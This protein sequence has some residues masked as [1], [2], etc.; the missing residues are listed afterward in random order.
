MGNIKH[1]TFKAFPNSSRMLSRRENTLRKRK[2]LKGKQSNM[3]ERTH[4]EHKSRSIHIIKPSS[5]PCQTLVP[6]GRGAIAGIGKVQIAKACHRPGRSSGRSG[7]RTVNGRPT[8]AESEVD[9]RRVHPRLLERF[10][11]LLSLLERFG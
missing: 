3:H 10:G 11:A 8:S 5:L 1:D 9:E 4:K 7:E 6:R 2:A